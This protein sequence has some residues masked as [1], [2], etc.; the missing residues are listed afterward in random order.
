MS[1]IKIKN[2]NKIN[3]ELTNYCNAA[4]PMCARYSIDGILNKE[5]VNTMHTSLALIK[6]KIGIDVIKRLQNFTSCGNLG[7]GA[8]NPECLEIY[9]WLRQTNPTLGLNL[10]TN[11]G[12]RTPE[13]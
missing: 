9:K 4:C 6:E 8:M 1:Y 7:D 5:I 13:F 12:A 2:L 11:G 10:H 3:A